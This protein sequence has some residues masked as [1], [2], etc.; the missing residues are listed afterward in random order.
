MAVHFKK[1]FLPDISAV[2]MKEIL[3]EIILEKECSNSVSICKSIYSVANQITS[4]SEDHFLTQPIKCTYKGKRSLTKKIEIISHT[5][6]NILMKELVCNVTPKNAGI[7]LG[8]LSGLRIGEV[9]AL[10]WEDINYEEGFLNINY[11]VQRISD[12][13]NPGKTILFLSSPKSI[14]SKR[15]IP[16]S[17]Q[18]TKILKKLK[19]RGIYVVGNK[20]PMEPRTLQLYFARLQEKLG[21]EV[22]NFHSLRHTFATNCIENGAD[23]KALSEILGHSDVKITLNRYVHPSLESKKKCV[24]CVSKIY[25]NIEI[26]GEN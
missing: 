2:L 17:E 22:H 20:K 14:T 9:C 8:L 3:N 4:F 26:D 10:R 23:I 21:M 6:Q 25:K 7:C 19:R 16:L 18:L 15:E 24:D 5:E 1:I 13:N 12:E 11:S